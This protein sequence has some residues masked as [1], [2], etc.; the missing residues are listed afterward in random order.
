MVVGDVSHARKRPCTTTPL[1][2]SSGS[3]WLSCLDAMMDEKKE[4]DYM[5]YIC[6]PQGCTSRSLTKLSFRTGW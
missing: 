5:F 4:P 1:V 2:S 3:L 6:L